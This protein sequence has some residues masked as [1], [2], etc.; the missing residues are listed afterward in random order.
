MGVYK[1]MNTVKLEIEEDLVSLLS[2]LNQPV[3]N[4]ARELIVLEMYR[5]GMISSGKAAQLLNMARLEF[6]HHASKLGIP[7][8]QMTE[9]EWNNEVKRS[10]TI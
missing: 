10:K 5:R 2:Q 1:K 9:D 3:Q 4:V 8:F 6:I 7:Y